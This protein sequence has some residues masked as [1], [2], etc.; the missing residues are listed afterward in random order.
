MLYI[1]LIL[2][3]LLL[4]NLPI[5]VSFGRK[6]GIKISAKRLHFLS[7]LKLKKEL[8]IRNKLAEI[9]KANKESSK[10]DK[11]FMEKRKLKA[12]KDKYF[13]LFYDEEKELHKKRL[14]L[15]KESK[16]KGVIYYANEKGDIYC[17]SKEGNRIYIKNR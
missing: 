3:C 6:I 4:I 12:F 5:I 2:L 9:D 8:K 1:E 7:K 16:W 17:I 10:N 15:K 14:F 11:L 13:D